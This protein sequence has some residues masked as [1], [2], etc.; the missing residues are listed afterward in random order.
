VSGSSLWQFDHSSLINNIQNPL[1]LK[2]TLPVHFASPPAAAISSSKAESL[3]EATCNAFFDE[4]IDPGKRTITVFDLKQG[5]KATLTLSSDSKISIDIDDNVVRI[6]RVT[7]EDAV[8]MNVY[9]LPDLISRECFNLTYIPSD[10]CRSTCGVSF[11]K[12]CDVFVRHFG[13]SVNI[14]LSHGPVSISHGRLV[15]KACEPLILRTRKPTVSVDLR[16]KML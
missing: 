12:A 13:N 15:G 11:Q 14:V 10:C 2:S 3:G 6:Y 1:N 9:R 16:K 7:R 5:Y 8:E 4:S